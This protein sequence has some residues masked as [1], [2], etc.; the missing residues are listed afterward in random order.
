MYETSNKNTVLERKN[1]HG[2]YKKNAE[3][4]TVVLIGCEAHPVRVKSQSNV[5]RSCVLNRRLVLTDAVSGEEKDGRV[6][7]FFFKK[8]AK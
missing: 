4:C 5:S 7:E 8:K 6:R 1:N 2:G 3:K